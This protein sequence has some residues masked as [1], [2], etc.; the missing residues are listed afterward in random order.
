MRKMGV[1]VTK[2]LVDSSLEPH[3]LRGP[4]GQLCIFLTAVMN[5]AAPYLIKCLGN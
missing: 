4:D 2:Q 5:R 3:C 1:V